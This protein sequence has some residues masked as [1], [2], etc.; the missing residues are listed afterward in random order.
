MSSL[1]KWLCATQRSLKAPITEL[2]EFKSQLIK[3]IQ[4]HKVRIKAQ[5]NRRK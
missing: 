3:V 2:L 4:Y 1:P 5:D